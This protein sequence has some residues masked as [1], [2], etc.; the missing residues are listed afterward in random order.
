M[1][2]GYSHDDSNY[3]TFLLGR[4]LTNGEENW[5]VKELEVYKIIYE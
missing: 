2:K 1:N 5:D 3:N 4:K